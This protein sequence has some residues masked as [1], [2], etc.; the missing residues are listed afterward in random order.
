[1]KNKIKSTLNKLLENGQL[2]KGLHKAND[3]YKKKSGKDYSK[4]INKG[5]DKLKK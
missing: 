1:M 3:M 2:E 5:M 4:Y